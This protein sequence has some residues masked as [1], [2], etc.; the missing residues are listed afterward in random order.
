MDT[1]RFVLIAEGSAEGEL[2]PHLRRL[3]VEAGAREA[4]GT[5]PDLARL[6]SPPGRS[7]GAKVAAVLALDDSLDLI[8]VHKD[9]DARD[10]SSARNEISVGTADARADLETVP[11]VPIQEFEAWLLVSEQAIRDVVGKPNGRADLRIPTRIESAAR[12]KEILKRALAAASETRGRRLAAVK[13]LF[14]V[15][16]RILIS[17]IDIHGPITALGAWQQL[18][19]DVD[20]AVNGLMARRADEVA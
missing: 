18:R 17:R 3:C 12:P 13:R 10:A 6:P 5:F 11:V 15:H 1:I 14:G 20:A 16:R 9:A 19:A 4:I 7:V 8:F 2:V